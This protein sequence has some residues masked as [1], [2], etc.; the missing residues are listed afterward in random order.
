M[1]LLRAKELTLQ[2]HS[3]FNALFE[4]TILT[5]ISLSFCYFTRSI[6]NTRVDSS[7]L[8]CSFEESLATDFGNEKEKQFF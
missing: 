4:S 3:L 2:H 5:T 7:I 8:Y 1:L 6:G